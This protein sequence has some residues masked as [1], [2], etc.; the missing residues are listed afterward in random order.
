MPEKIKEDKEDKETRIEELRKATLYY[1]ISMLEIVKM[2]DLTG[3]CEM[4]KYIIEN[5][6]GLLK[7]KEDDIIDCKLDFY[8]F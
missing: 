3:K 7:P 5:G 2:Y 6:K 4:M 8:Y 1:E